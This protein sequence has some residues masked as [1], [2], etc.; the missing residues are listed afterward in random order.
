MNNISITRF[1]MH[2]G[3]SHVAKLHA[4]TH[5]LRALAFEESEVWWLKKMCLVSKSNERK[6]CLERS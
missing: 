3:S 4:S 1:S 6:Q 5:H 2:N